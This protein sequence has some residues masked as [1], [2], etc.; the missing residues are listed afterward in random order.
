MKEEENTETERKLKGV[1][2]TVFQINA[3]STLKR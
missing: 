1:N 3:T 2:S